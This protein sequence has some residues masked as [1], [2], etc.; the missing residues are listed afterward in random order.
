[1]SDKINF[2][3]INASDT[4]WGASLAGYRFHKELQRRGFGSH[5]MCAVKETNDTSVS[6]IV[7]VPFG[8]IPNAIIGKAFNAFGLQSFGYPS[9]FFLKNSKLVNEWADVAILRDLH[10]WY[11]SLSSLED[12]SAKVPLIWRCPDVWALTGHCVYPG[13]C[14]R[15]E[16]GCGRCPDLKQYPDLFFDTTRWLLFRKKRIYEKIKNRLVFVSPS[17]WLQKMLKNSPTT[18][19]VRCELIPTAIDLNVFRPGARDESREK[20]NIKREDK[21]IMFSSVNL[22]DKRKGIEDIV[23]VINALSDKIDGVITVIFLGVHNKKL[24]FRPE[25]N[26]KGLGFVRDDALIA[27]YYNAADVFLSM[28]KADN[29]PNT[30]IE[31]AACGVPVVTLDSGGCPE[32][33]DNAGSGYVVKDNSEAIGA[34]T[35]ILNDDDKRIQ[36]SKRARI[37]AETNFS[38]DRQAKAYISLARELM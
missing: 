33:V 23:K 3:H 11:F 16:T 37:L 7:P 19:F 26:V 28:S 18:S 9:S 36:F 27:Q 29:L 31:A 20:L 4:R 2:L 21:V 32:A 6:S 1:M 14:R 25:I 8:Y 5:L 13:K 17:K 22:A 34:L 24:D 15:W 35:K 38:M 12:L 10:W 30:L